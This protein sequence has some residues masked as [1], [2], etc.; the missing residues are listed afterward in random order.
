MNVQGGDRH[1]IIRL[2]K[3]CHRARNASKQSLGC[4]HRGGRTLRFLRALIGG[5]FKGCGALLLLLFSRWSVSN[6]TANERV[7]VEA[8]RF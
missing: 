1:R 3:V 5:K 6:F 4:R 7:F 2:R 8:L